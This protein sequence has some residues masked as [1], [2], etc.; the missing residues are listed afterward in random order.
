MINRHNSW[1]KWDPP[2]FILRAQEGEQEKE[3]S[4]EAK[5]QDLL[6]IHFLFLFFF[7]TSALLVCFLFIHFPNSPFS[8]FFWLT[9]WLGVYIT[10]FLSLSLQSF[11]SES[12]KEEKWRENLVVSRLL[13][14]HYPTFF[15]ALHS[16]A[17]FF[18]WGAFIFLKKKLFILSSEK[19]HLFNLFLPLHPL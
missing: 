18:F 12:F 9:D 6:F 8:S 10:P 19:F 1:R 4:S 2:S 13:F 5:K 7:F 15:I 3:R 17:L 14:L 16:T 11:Q